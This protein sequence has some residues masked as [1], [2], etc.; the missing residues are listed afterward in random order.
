MRLPPDV[1]SLEQ[2]LELFGGQPRH[3][4]LKQPRPD[5]PLPALD[6]LVHDDKAVAMP[7]KE[8][9]GV[10][11]AADKDQQCAGE[12][13]DLHRLLGERRK[14]VAPLPRMR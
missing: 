7:V 13:I 2:P 8:L 4:F 14:A 12:G 11:A 9:H 10:M 3:F 1:V 6:H 5:E